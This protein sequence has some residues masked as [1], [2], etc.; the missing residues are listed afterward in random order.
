MADFLHEDAW[1]LLE[2]RLHQSILADTRWTNEDEWFASH[3]SDVEWSEV[4]LGVNVDVILIKRSEMV[5]Y[6]LG[7]QHRR[8][9]IVQ[10]LPNLRVRLN[11]LLV[12]HD[13]LFFA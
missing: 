12:V 9:E 3:R 1:I 5:T 13:E 2:N 10:H 4:F 6:R 7:Q 8:N 11:V